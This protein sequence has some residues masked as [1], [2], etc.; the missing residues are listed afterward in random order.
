MS[1]GIFPSKTPEIKV[2]FEDGDI[3]VVDK[4]AG[5]VS[6]NTPKGEKGITE[7]LTNENRKNLFLLHRLDRDVGGVMVFAKNKESAA[8]LS[9]DIRENRFF[10]TYLAVP[11]GVPEE[12]TG[13]Y[14]DLLFRD[15]RKNRSYIVDR[16]RKGVKK[17]SLEYEVLAQK[18][19]K[20]LVSVLLH[21]GR[22]HQIRVQFSSRKMPLAGDGHYGSKEKC[23]I[24]LYSR[25]IVLTHPKTGEEM[26]FEALPN[27]TKY[28]WCLFGDVK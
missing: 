23:K 19:G 17:A 26:A 5:L 22:T 27:I 15:A 21:T 11:D 14:E 1:D 8:K 2:I 24:A 3:L 7:Y 28:P 4:P 10:K 6:E 13:I 18:E 12:K 16:E 20:A 9:E 25:K